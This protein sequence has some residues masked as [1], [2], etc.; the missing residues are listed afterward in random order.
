MYLG[1]ILAGLRR[2]GLLFLDVGD[3]DLLGDL[4]LFRGDL[5]SL[6]SRSCLSLSRPL[7]RSRSLS[8]YD[9]MSGRRVGCMLGLGPGGGSKPTNP[10]AY[11]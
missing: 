5:F 11:G 1:T 3:L 8:L 4:D 7:S 10:T 9:C 2:G 6:R